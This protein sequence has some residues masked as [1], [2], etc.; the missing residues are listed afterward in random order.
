MYFSSADVKRIGLI[1][2]VAILLLWVFAIIIEKYEDLHVL[3]I[4]L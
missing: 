4:N 3:G 1:I 2:S